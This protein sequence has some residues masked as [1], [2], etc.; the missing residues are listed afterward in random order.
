MRRVIGFSGFKFSL[1]QKRTPG[2]RAGQVHSLNAS[3]RVIVRNQDW[4]GAPSLR[5]LQGWGFSDHLL[6][7]LCGC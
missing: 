7:I 1:P 4:P 5:V 2:T 6:P 3:F